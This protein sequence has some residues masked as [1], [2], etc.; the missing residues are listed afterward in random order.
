[1]YIIMFVMPSLIAYNIWNLLQKHKKEKCVS[2][3]SNK[4]IS[5][6]CLLF[7][8]NMC[9]CLLSSIRGCVGFDFQEMSF[10]Y[11]VKYAAV[12]CVSGLIIVGLL[13]NV[14]IHTYSCSDISRNGTIDFMK[15]VFSIIIVLFHY[16]FSSL[17]NNSRL[18]INGRIGV[19][20]FFLVSGFF[21]A[22]SANR[23]YNQKLIGRATKDYLWNKIKG[24]CPEVFIAF[25]FA[26]LVNHLVSGISFEKMIKDLINSVFELFFLRMGGLL[27]VSS[28]GNTWYISAM[29]LS[30]L[31]LFL[32]LL[33]NKD[34]YLYIIAPL[35][36]IFFL[37]YLCMEKGSVGVDG[38]WTGIVRAGMLR[39]TGEIALGSICYFICA[40][41]K[42]ICFTDKMKCFLTAVEVMLYVYVIIDTY[43]NKTSTLDF[44]LIVLLAIAII[45]SF[46]GHSK[47]TQVFNKSLFTWLGK[48]SFSIYLGHGFWRTNVGVLFQNVNSRGYLWIY[49]VLTFLTAL[50]ITVISEIIRDYYK[51]IYKW[52]KKQCI[53]E[54]T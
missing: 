35:I 48:F 53:R 43:T 24:M 10:S 49:L 8:T 34:I 54:N 46:S 22:Q 45:I 26:F 39:S 29:L 50:V 51:K 7:I 19:E 28:N 47:L 52:L 1:M 11:S 13:R 31:I 17:A 18:F 37:G 30:M 21:M 2:S 33:K 41:V 16:T 27:G 38:Q 4:I 14:R 5:L 23:Y 32:M 36:S 40:E 12:S 3:R 9:A 6:L 44:V 20:F 25:S 15:F 42:K